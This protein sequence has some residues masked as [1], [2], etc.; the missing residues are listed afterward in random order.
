M[1]MP[2]VNILVYGHRRDQNNHTFYR[3]WLEA[4]ANGRSPFGLSALAAVAFIRVVT[5]PRFP[6]GP[7]PLSVAL[8]VVD[9][10]CASP[11]CQWMLP[12]N[13]H[14]AT[15]KTLTPP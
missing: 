4:L 7:T 1:K 9:Q 5:H 14:W 6:N 13:R 15:I 2:D 12:G 11:N 10:L 3:K 8:T